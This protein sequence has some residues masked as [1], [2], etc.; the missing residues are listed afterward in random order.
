VNR[1]LFARLRDVC[2]GALDRPPGARDAYLAQ[3]CAGDRQLHEQARVLL[4]LAADQHSVLRTG[5]ALSLFDRID[6]TAT[7]ERSADAG[8]ERRSPPRSSAQ[9]PSPPSAEPPLAAGAIL[10]QRY[11]VVRFLGAGGMGWVYEAIDQ[12]LSIRL[13]LKMLRMA[14]VD[15]CVSTEAVRRLKREVL[16]ARTI[17]HPHVCRTYDLG[18]DGEG[19]E[20]TWFLTMELLPGRTLSEL[21]RRRARLSPTEALPLIEQMSAALGA[22]HRAGIVHRDFKSGNVMVADVDG[23]P[24][25]VVMDFGLAIAMAS[26]EPAVSDADP[27]AT[28]APLDDHRPRLAGTPEYMSPEQV[29]GLDVTAQSDIY[30][31]G[32]VIY[33]MVTGALPFD[34]DTPW[35][36]ALQ[37]LV[38]TARAPHTL[39]PDLDERW[40]TTILRCLEREPERRFSCVEHVAAVLAGRATVE[41]LTT[42]FTA[43]R[44]HHLPAE[45]NA[46]VG[47]DAELVA[48]HER[49]TGADRLV[50]LTGTAGIGKT[51]LAVHYGW[52]YLDAW[53]GG[54]WFCDLSEARGLDG[55]ASAVAAALD[56]PLQSGDPLTQLGHA[57]GARGRILLIL[58]NFE[59]VVRHAGATLGQ[60]LASTH[61]A[62][63]LVT[64]R[65]RVRL[66]GEVTETLDALATAGDGRRLFDVRAG[67]Y[68]PGWVMADDD[69]RLVDE[70]VETLD[71]IPLA[72]ELAASRTRLL[73]LEQLRDRL[74]DRLRLLARGTRGRHE[75]LRAA[76]DWSW[77]LLQPWERS[78]AMQASVFE[79]GC[80]LEAAEAVIDLSDDRHAPP[81]LD[82]I[83]ALVDKSWLRTSVVSR[84]PRFEMYA[85]VQEYLSA[86]RLAV[87]RE[88]DHDPAARATR[89][90]AGAACRHGAHY[91]AMGTVE[92]IT[93]LDRHGGTDRRAALH[94]E[95][96][97]LVTACRRALARQDEDTVVAT[98]IAASQVL[99][100]RGPIGVA[101]RLGRDVI[102][103]VESPPQ[104]ARTLI[105]LG[106]AESKT[107]DM[108][109]AR[110]HF[111]EALAISRQVGDRRSEGVALAYLG[112]LHDDQGRIVEAC[113]H[114]QEALRVHREQG[115]RREEGI[116]LGNLGAHHEEQGHVAEA[117]RHYEA[118]RAI[119]DELGDWRG[120]ATVLGNLA[121]L[122][123]L[124]GHMDVARECYEAALSLR[125]RLGDRASEGLVR[126][127]L[128]IFH[129]RLGRI[130][131]AQ[132]QYEAALAIHRELGNR[133]SEAFAL[134]NLGCL[135]KHRGRLAESRRY[136]EASLAIHRELGNRRSEGV[137]LGNLGALDA[138]EGRL[139]AA[140]PRYE[141][142]LAIH[143]EVGNRRLEGIVLCKLGAL[144]LRQCLDEG[145]CMLVDGI[146]VLREVNDPLELGTFLCVLGR[147][148]AQQGETSAA[149]GLL[150]EAAAIAEALAVTPESE[151]ACSVDELRRLLDQPPP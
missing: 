77:D 106:S 114:H 31:L 7:S 18:C 19:D 30:A 113:E 119:H 98:Y 82:V 48:L 127:N 126:G 13:A 4:E 87:E 96:D 58:D 55:I 143:R 14:P 122:E 71:G 36:I 109:E 108:T 38:E 15:A 29:L 52:R 95:L 28:G 131:E 81:A 1:A 65:E 22:A 56:V 5:G 80:T 124:Q 3:V 111:E 25:A 140:R 132:R 150:A 43:H 51:R 130:D 137:V 145:R 68:R 144:L 74:S 50:T 112:A 110:A 100:V 57:I 10:A 104:R 148:H 118:A 59:Q 90:V 76:L 54:V 75:T 135:Y 103:Q 101:V 40:T 20:T 138:H 39:V 85:I 45:S 142:A 35:D 84:A 141:S 147:H 44:R 97:N 47:R 33:Q 120:M 128:G 26:Q 12:L 69:R 46:F 53:P 9:P 34:G 6:R 61:E 146:R 151:L 89:T 72:I 117:R 136:L 63:F 102:D 21:I 99:V 125:R 17:T 94:L 86:R 139:E 42:T 91:A 62:R 105:T 64:S 49:L 73:G 116:V 32:V 67:E 60:W 92:S 2:A 133:R 129:D 27:C 8:P 66:A 16:L 78:A 107:G 134:S 11:R 123:E 115:N 93:L 37:R 70:I 24:H 121:I 83:Q 88:H 41:H 23:A 79:G 149:G